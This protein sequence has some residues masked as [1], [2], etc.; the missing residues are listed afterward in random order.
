MKPKILTGLL[1]EEISALL[2]QNKKQYRGVQIFRWIHEHCAVSFDE[3][4]NLPKSFRKEI[5][6]QFTIEALK[7][8]DV[9]TSSDNSTHKYLWELHDGNRIESV[10]IRD[11]G[12]TTAC[13]STQIGCKMGCSFCRTGKMRFIRNLTTGEIVDQLISM[14]RHLRTTGKDISNI[15]FMGMGEPLDNTNEVI[16]AVKI[17]S[18]ETALMIS[19]RKIT[20]STSGLIPGIKLFSSELKQVGLAI[21]LN[22]SED[23]L[24][25]KLMPVNRRYPLDKL[26]DAAL[27]YAR[28]LKKRITFEYILI[29]GINNSPEHAKKLL[30]IAR[31]IPS[32]V[33]LIAFNE[34]PESPFKRPTDEKNEAFQKILIDGYVTAFL[35]K[36]KG[37]DI[38]A[39]C[40]QLA[41]K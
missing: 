3:M 2:P 30:T 24:R 29:D 5:Q 35:R 17:I 11:A 26:L 38:L 23:R 25:S 40:G 1:P 31:R 14:R 4:T 21:S 13:V 36:S 32:K 39:A 37:T 15:V 12:R 7:N 22:A 8:I 10:I 34:F 27:D 18:M 9:L 20:V 28:R 6:D 33:N 16:K 19:R 41:S